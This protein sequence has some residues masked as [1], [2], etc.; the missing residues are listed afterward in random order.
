MNLR[1]QKILSAVI[2]EYTNTA[3]AVPSDLIVKKY[4]LKVSPATIR[5]D[6]NKLEE[7]GLLYQPHISSGRIPTDKGYR[8]FVEEIMKDKELSRDDQQKLQRELLKLKV[9][10]KRLTKTTAK[11]LSILSGNLAVSGIPNKDEFAEFGMRDLLEQPEFKKLDEVCR[12]AE[13]LDSIDINVDKLA[14][15]MKIGETKIFIGKENP[16]TDMP[17]CAMMVSPYKLKSGEKGVLA[18]IGPKRM[19]YAKNKSLLNYM[20][21]LLGA[22][23]V[24]LLVISNL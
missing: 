23:V 13:V 15:G 14:K 3:V 9:Q 20:K 4:K 21:K 2:E 16:V 5:S 17:D 12:L 7:E 24:I 8:Y 1:Q 6:M 18:L 22:S 11:L 10:N 19:R